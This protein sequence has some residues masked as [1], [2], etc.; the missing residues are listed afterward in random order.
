MKVIIR[1]LLPVLV[2]AL[3]F[4]CSADENTII[5]QYN[6]LSKKIENKEIKNIK[7][8]YQNSIFL[9]GKFKIV[10]PTRNQFVIYTE[11]DETRHVFLFDEV[12]ESFDINI[13]IEK[14]SYLKNGILLNDD[15]FLGVEGNVNEIINTDLK[16]LT[17]NNS[18]QRIDNFKI[19]IHKWF[20]KEDANFNE[21]SVDNLINEV[22]TS[23]VLT[24]KGD[25][26]A[27]G[28]GF[29][30]CS[31]GGGS[32]GCSVSCGSGYYACCNVT[33]IGPNDCHCD[34]G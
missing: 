30:G 21:L 4:S 1:N 28:E 31:I 8:N 9:K 29:T 19:L 25:C 11:T 15:L 5:D 2:L 33:T 34:K 18:I 16:I 14:L 6:F 12:D 20:D 26:D 27:G 23:A 7:A 13:N 17:N 32:S 10:K 24:H 3:L 22:S